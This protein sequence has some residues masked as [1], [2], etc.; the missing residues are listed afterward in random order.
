MTS[1]VSALIAWPGPCIVDCCDVFCDWLRR[2][3]AIHRMW[4]DYCNWNWT[5]RCRCVYTSCIHLLLKIIFSQVTWLRAIR[6]FNEY[7]YTYFRFF[8]GCT[9]L[10]VAVLASKLE[11]S[12]AEKHVHNFMLDSQLA[13]DV[14]Q[15]DADNCD[16]IP[17][18][19][20]L[21]FLQRYFTI[22]TPKLRNKYPIKKETRGP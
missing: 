21:L 1:I 4:P 10:T 18:L 11:L 5:D 16:E 14:C 8:Q 15:N 7:L 3:R 22:L 13:K 17:L 20:T 6:N 12:R 9:A 2:Y 19:S